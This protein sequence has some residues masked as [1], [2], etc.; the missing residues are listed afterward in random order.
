M[1]WCLHD[2]KRF[3]LKIINAITVD[4]G[5]KR[6]IIHITNRCCAACKLKHYSGIIL[7]YTVQYNMIL[8]TS[9][10]WRAGY[11]SK[12]E[13]KKTAHTSPVRASYGVSF[14]TILERIDRVKT[15]PHC[16]TLHKNMSTICTVGDRAHH[17][18]C[19]A[20]PWQY[21]HIGSEKL[22]VHLLFSSSFE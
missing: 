3:E 17:T 8:Y 1:S 20:L 9:L 5:T 14:V 2:F 12:Y 11:E 10:W 15:A 4:S 18:G 21:N 7:T 22:Y 6:K 13:P 16:I 19:T